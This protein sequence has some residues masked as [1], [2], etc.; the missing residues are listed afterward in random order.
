METIEALLHEIP[1][2]AGMTD[3]QLELI[4][5][6]GSNQRLEA[7]EYLFREGEPADNF[8][9][10]RH[11]RISLELF[12]Q[13]RGSIVIETLEAGELIG[14]SWLFPPYTWHFDARAVDLCRLT[15]FD[16]ACLR[17]KFEDD[18]A[19]GYAAMSRFAQLLI[20]SLQWTQHRLLDVYG[21]SR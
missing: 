2:F 19:F 7:G 13:P 17:G 4:A 15:K 1:F 6:C 8:Y 14:W 10:L 20:E 16:G 5:G 12:A 9:C 11:G 3:E 18:P 21:H